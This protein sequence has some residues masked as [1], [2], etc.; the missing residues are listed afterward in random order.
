[1]PTYFQIRVV[2]HSPILGGRYFTG[3][4]NSNSKLYEGTE[5]GNTRRPLIGTGKILV[6]NRSLPLRTVGAGGVSAIQWRT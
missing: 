4:Q 3:R 1:M 5:P 2:S 6:S